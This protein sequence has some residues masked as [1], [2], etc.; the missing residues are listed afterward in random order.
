[1]INPISTQMPHPMLWVREELGSPKHTAQA[2]LFW[3][4]TTNTAH[5]VV[6]RIWGILIMTWLS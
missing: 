4:G 6:K 3:Q 2:Q 1:M 5:K